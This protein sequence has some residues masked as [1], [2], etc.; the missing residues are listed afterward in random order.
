MFMLLE[1]GEAW[2][3]ISAIASTFYIMIGMHL[4]DRVKL[5]KHN[6]D[7]FRRVRRHSSTSESMTRKGVEG[8]MRAAGKAVAPIDS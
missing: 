3:I 5:S 1:F 6:H 4:T 7:S 2:L 8:I